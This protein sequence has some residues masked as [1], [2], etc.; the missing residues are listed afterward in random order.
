MP[1]IRIA[2]V[3]PTLNEE[4]NIKLFC[5][6]HQFAD[7]IIISDGGSV[8]KTVGIA[9]QFPNVEIHQFKKKIVLQDSPDGFMNHE[10]EHFNA[11]LDIAYN[12]KFDWI[13]FEGTDQF[14][15]KILENNIRGILEETTAPALYC[16]RINMWQDTMYFPRMMLPNWRFCYGWNTA[17]RV[18]FVNKQYHCQ[19]LNIP[20]NNITLDPPYCV[21]HNFCPDDKTVN[22][23]LQRY[24]AWG[25][26]QIH[27]L[28]WIYAPPEPMPLWALENRNW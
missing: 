11:A 9:S 2:V 19:M 16:Y 17:T 7:K 24:A 5:E 10:G 14:P 26:P 22:K 4:E 23:K 6:R 27:P 8:D 12:Q 15:N 28:Q 3:C 18:R 1:K 21:M 13:I 20:R 25:V